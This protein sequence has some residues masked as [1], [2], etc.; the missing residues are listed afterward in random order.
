MKQHGSNE[1]SRPVALCKP[2]KVPGES[3]GLTPGYSVKYDGQQKHA[4]NQ[5]PQA[6]KK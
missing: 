3:H 6:G 1:I 5:A 4:T 2:R